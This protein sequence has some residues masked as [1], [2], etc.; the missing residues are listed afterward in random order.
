MSKLKL[1][2]LKMSKCQKNY[3]VLKSNQSKFYK[4]YVKVKVS[5]K[6]LNSTFQQQKNYLKESSCTGAAAATGTPPNLW[7]WS[8][9]S[10]NFMDL[11]VISSISD[12]NIWVIPQ[13]MSDPLTICLFWGKKSEFRRSAP[14]QP[15]PWSNPIRQLDLTNW[16]TEHSATSFE[17]FFQVFRC[18]IEILYKKMKL[19]KKNNVGLFFQGV[20]LMKTYKYI[21]NNIQT[22]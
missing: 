17:N 9:N 22:C 6:L 4:K 2:L 12:L 21:K 15:S 5:Q 20:S 19:K 11:S 10:S 7:A 18:K 13:Y 8:P 1:K 3:F 14:N 16:Q